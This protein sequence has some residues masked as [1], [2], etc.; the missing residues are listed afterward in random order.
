MQRPIILNQ[1]VDVAIP[2]LGIKVRE[3]CTAADL[4]TQLQAVIAAAALVANPYPMIHGLEL[5]GGGGGATYRGSLTVTRE[6]GWGF[7]TSIPAAAAHVEIRSARNRRQIEEQLTQIYAAIAAAATELPYVWQVKVV[8]T[9]RD[10]SY[11]IGVLWSNGFPGRPT[12]SVQET[13]P[14]GPYLA[15]TTIQTLT[16]PRTVLGLGA[17]ETTWR[18]EWGAA[19]NDTTSSGAKLRLELDLGTLVEFEEIGSAA[20][21]RSNESVYVHTQSSAADSVFG[22]VIEPTVGGNAVSCRG[23]HLV[24]TMMNYNLA[25]S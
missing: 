12:I 18:I 16:I 7:G 15:A 10:G 4:Q 8:G 20:E 11:L 17:T 19:V 5:G 22:L 25:N 3:A 14:Q 9:G 6:L 21:W 24:A 2:A 23:A 13:A 1:L